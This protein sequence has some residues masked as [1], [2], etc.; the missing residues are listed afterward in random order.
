VGKS[1]KPTQEEFTELRAEVAELR[2]RIDAIEGALNAFTVVYGIR[3]LPP[4]GDGMT[5]EA[6]TSEVQARGEDR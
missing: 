6:D 1:P 5:D 2:D 3:R 4:P